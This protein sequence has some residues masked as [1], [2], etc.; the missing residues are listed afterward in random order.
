[1]P[2]DSKSMVQKS[3]KH[4]EKVGALSAETKKGSLDAHTES[5]PSA[6]EAV[7][8]AFD[9]PMHS[10]AIHTITKEQSTPFLESPFVQIQAQVRICISPSFITT[11]LEG[12]KNY[13]NTFIMRY[14]AELDGVV[15]AYE[16]VKLVTKNGHIMNESP[17]IFFNAQAKFTLFSPKVGSILYGVVNK[18]SPDHIGLLVYGVFNTSIPSSHICNKKFSWDAEGY[19]WKFESAIDHSTMFIATNSIIKFS[20]DSLITANKMLAISGSLTSHP[21]DTGVIDSTGLP[22]PTVLQPVEFGNDMTG[23]ETVQPTHFVFNDEVDEP[24]EECIKDHD[25]PTHH[26]IDTKEQSIDISVQP[27]KPK[28]IKSSSS[29]RKRDNKLESTLST[30]P[31]KKSKNTN[32]AHTSDDKLLNSAAG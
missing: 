31:K 17:F 5:K 20:V 23:V 18:V 21:T 8:S 30:T 7:Q 10:A 2:I 6:S 4:M 11:P 19:A 28:T 26:E 25:T 14:I 24:V 1:M 12:V 27:A 29:K 32:V 9:S 3:L 22:M 13:L 15:L 16:N